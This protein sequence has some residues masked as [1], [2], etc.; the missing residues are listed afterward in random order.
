[1]LTLPGAAGGAG[2]VEHDE[3]IDFEIRSSSGALLYAGRLQNRVSRLTATGALSFRYQIRDTFTGLPGQISQ[4]RTSAFV[5]FATDVDYSSTSTGTVAPN[6]GARSPDAEV[7]AFFFAQTPVH[8]GQRS[9]FLHIDSNA[10]AFTTGGFTTLQLISGETVDVPTV[11]PLLDCNS[12]QT[13]DAVDLATGASQDVNA[14]EVPDECEDESLLI[15]P[16][17]AQALAQLESE[18]L[19]VPR[20]LFTRATRPIP[21]FVRVKVPVPPNLP[22]DPLV[23]ALDFLDRHRMLYDLPDPRTD[24]YLLRVVSE[25]DSVNL[26]FG[27]QRGGI[28]VEASSLVLSM[29]ANASQVRRTQGYYVPNIPQFDPPSTTQQQAEEM[30]LFI[31]SNPGTKVV[32]DRTL[33]YFNYGLYSGQPEQTYLA[34]RIMLTDGGAHWKYFID[35]HSGAPLLRLELTQSGGCAAETEGKDFDLNTALDSSSDICWDSPFS[36]DTEQWFDECGPLGAYP[37][38]CGLGWGGCFPP[39]GCDGDAEPMFCYA[40]ETYDYFNDAFNWDS[41]DNDFEELEGYVHWGDGQCPGI[42]AA[43]NSYYECLMFCDDMVTKDVVGHE[44]THLIISSTSGLVY[45]DQPG[46]LNE[47]YADFFGAMVEDDD[48]WWVADGSADASGA[49]TPAGQPAGTIRIMDDPPTC[50]DPDHMVA[51]MSGD[52][53]GLRAGCPSEEIFG[54]EVFDCSGVRDN[55]RVHTNSGI[56]NKAATLIVDGGTHNGL[57]ITGIGRAKT[58][59]LYFKVMRNLSYNARFID[60]REDTVAKAQ[61]WADDGTHD[62]TDADVCSVVNAFASVGLGDADFDCDGLLDPDDP[63]SDGDGFDNDE[64]GCPDIPSFDNVDTDGDGIGDLCEDDMDGDG[65][66]DDSNGDGFV[67]RNTC[68]GGDTTNC[69]DNCPLVPNPDQADAD[70]NGRGDVCQDDDEDGILNPD[71]NCRYVYTLNQTDSDG[72][73]PDPLPP[74]GTSC[75]DACDADDDNDGIL[76]DGDGSGA[77]WDNPCTGG[78]TTICDDNCRTVANANQADSDVRVGGGLGDGVGDVCDVCGGAGGCALVY[79]PSQVDTDGDGCGNECDSDDDGDEVVD[80]EDNCPLTDNPEQIDLDENG[81][82]LACDPQEAWIFDGLP[83]LDG[84][85]VFGFIAFPEVEDVLR[86]PI[87]PCAS[88]NCP[89]YFSEGFR[90]TVT[91]TLP[92]ADMRARMADDLG[93]AAD[94]ADFGVSERTFS[95]S[96]LSDFHYVPP[97]PFGPSSRMAG[98]GNPAGSGGEPPFRGRKYYLELRA[99]PQVVPGVNYPISIGVRSVAL[100]E[101]QTPV[102]EPSGTTKNR[103]LSFALPPEGSGVE[104]AVRVRLTSLHHPAP[105]IPPGTPNFAAFEGQFRYLNA[106]RDTANNPVFTCAD[107]A[108]SGTSYNCAR[109]GCTPEYRDWAGILGG[110]V[111]HVTGDSVIPSSQ[112]DVAQ[113]AASCA[114]NESACTAVSPVLTLVT[115]RWGNVDNSPIQGVPNAIDISKV[116]DKVKDVPGAF[117]E[118]RCQLREATP[119]PYGMAVN[120]LDI[121]RAVDAVKGQPYPFTLSGCP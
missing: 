9:R 64:D 103:F 107:S 55:G 76:D 4:L 84:E 10:N 33:V 74:L 110:A 82:G 30:A 68:R 113:L 94:K 46:A 56:P 35:A 15:S 69:D 37:D 102:A 78:D 26:F 34:W 104:T 66:T 17:I 117:I 91:A 79:D 62:F 118:P 47:S 98:A 72:D 71:D 61:D 49:C 115:E 25:G 90:T 93:Q 60:A 7:V 67:S 45:A 51:A 18:S 53:T 32:A 100:A 54:F 29:D 13:H 22:P 101:P 73:C 111:V 5:G 114:G 27:Q 40:H 11:Q 21:H 106:I 41:F 14:N 121:G 3:L 48:E 63:D 52:A 108:V 31:H 38:D 109:L 24:L 80:S 105:P 2:T 81:V 58:E 44:F 95:F 19:V 16:R 39:A 57:D 87:S 59:E 96:P 77:Q 28:T 112:Y 85:P 119:N 42:I 65:I 36:P 12:N 70:R 75:G 92:F 97:P 43:A 120:A 89:G 50:G 23:R 8:A 20:V 99:S 86:I 6:L 88:A 83:D 1:M 116:V